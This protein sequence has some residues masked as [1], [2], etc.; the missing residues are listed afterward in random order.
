MDKGDPICEKRPKR[1]QEKHVEGWKKE[2]AT[3]ELVIKSFL[4]VKSI[5][6]IRRYTC[7][8]PYHQSASWRNCRCACDRCGLSAFRPCPTH[9]ASSRGRK[10]SWRERRCAARAAVRSHSQPPDAVAP[11]ADLEFPLW[12]YATLSPEVWKKRLKYEKII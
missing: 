4:N 11:L 10:A 9:K 5:W 8:H 6:C 7:G 3:I 1:Q 12:F 2:V